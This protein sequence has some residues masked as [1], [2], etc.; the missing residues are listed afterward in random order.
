[1]ITA[2]LLAPGRVEAFIQPWPVELVAAMSAPT[3]DATH[4]RYFT[5]LAHVLVPD[6]RPGDLLDCS[7]TIQITNDL[8][9]QLVEY[10]AALVLTPDEYGVAGIADATGALFNLSAPAVQPPSG[11]FVTRFPGINVSPNPGGM[12]HCPQ[13]RHARYI[14][15]EDV[16]GDQWLA[17]IAYAAGQTFSP[18]NAVK[19][20]AACGDISVIRYR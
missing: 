16:S 7:A 20:D 15:P 11:R 4:P 8:P 12:H 3:Y 1:M 9:G 17:F 5:R 13:T 19:V 18:A 6:C 14:V 10:S 2:P